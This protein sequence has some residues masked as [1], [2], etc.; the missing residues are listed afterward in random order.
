VDA[1]QD[2]IIT[3]RRLQHGQRHRGESIYEGD[4]EVVDLADPHHWPDELRTIKDP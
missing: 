1:S 4:E 3:G 2:V